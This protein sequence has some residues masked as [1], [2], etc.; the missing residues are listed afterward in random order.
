MCGQ[1]VLPSVHVVKG[2]IDRENLGEASIIQEQRNS[3]KRDIENTNETNTAANTS[4]SLST[5][6]ESSSQMQDLSGELFRNKVNL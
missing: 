5:D 1:C 2:K 6:A 3:E 4:R